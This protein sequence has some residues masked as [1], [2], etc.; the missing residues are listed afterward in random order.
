MAD[1][2]NVHATCYTDGAQNTRGRLEASVTKFQYPSLRTEA[3]VLESSWR[4]GSGGGD[5]HR[6]VYLRS[7]LLPRKSKMDLGHDSC[8]P[9][10]PRY[11]HPSPHAAHAAEIVSMGNLHQQRVVATVRCADDVHPRSR[12]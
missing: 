3:H 11:L 12:A 1:D 5:G 2:D 10:P 6:I 4:A 7:G 8:L 9:H